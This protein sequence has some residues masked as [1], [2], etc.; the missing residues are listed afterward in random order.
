MTKID[1]GT[2]DFGQF[3]HRALQWV[4]TACIGVG[5]FVFNGFWSDFKE[6]KS[7]IQ[8]IKISLSEIREGNKAYEHRINAIEQRFEALVIRVNNK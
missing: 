6:M 2:I 7:D 8:E 4:I 5:C 1:L 3:F